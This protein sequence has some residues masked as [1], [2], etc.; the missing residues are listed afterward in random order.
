MH[1]QAIALKE[2]GF[3]AFAGCESMHLVS[4][5]LPSSLETIDRLYKQSLVSARLWPSLFLGLALSSLFIK[6]FPS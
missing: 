1:S 2:I 6:T 5:V 4:P 3:C